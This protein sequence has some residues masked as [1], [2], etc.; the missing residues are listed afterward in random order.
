MENDQPGQGV[1]NL[2]A[3]VFVF[4]LEALIGMVEADD[5]PVAR[6][7]KGRVSAPE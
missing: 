1:T 5:A 2:T 6:R 3:S 4:A 7:G